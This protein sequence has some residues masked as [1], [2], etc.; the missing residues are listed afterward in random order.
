MDD[1]LGMAAFFGQVKFKLTSE[2]KEEILYRDPCEVLRH[3]HGPGD[4]AEPLGRAP[5]ELKPGADSRAE[6]AR[7]LTAP[8]TP[9]SRGTSSTA[10]GLPS[11]KKERTMRGQSDRSVDAR[12]GFGRRDFIRAGGAAWGLARKPLSA[13]ADASPAHGKA[14]GKAKSVIQIGVAPYRVFDGPVW[15]QK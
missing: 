15:Q 6:F 13:L 1:D 7:W 8:K 5:M 11:S 12:V 9:G 4:C 3:S 2:W 10:F 14:T